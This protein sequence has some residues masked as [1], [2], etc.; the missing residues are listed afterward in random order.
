MKSKLAI[1]INAI[2]LIMLG[3]AFLIH[4]GVRNENINE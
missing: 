1:I 4:M 2:T 3:V